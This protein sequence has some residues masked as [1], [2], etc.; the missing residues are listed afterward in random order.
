MAMFVVVWVIVSTAMGQIVYAEAEDGLYASN[1][2]PADG[3]E[4]VETDVLL[5]WWPGFG[6]TEHDVYLGTDFD[7]VNDIFSGPWDMDP[8]AEYLG[9]FTEPN[10]LVTGLS[11]NTMYYWR[12]DEV[13]GRLP[14]PLAGGVIYKGDVWSFNTGG[15]GLIAH[16]KL[17]EGSGAVAYDS[18]GI[19]DGTIYG[20]AWITGQLG[21]ALDFDGSNDYVSIPHDP[22]LNIT[23]DITIAAWVNFTRI[24]EYEGIVTKCVGVG[25]QNVPF[26]FRTRPHMSPL[27]F[28]RADAS[29]HER[30][31]SSYIAELGEWHHV[32]VRVE[33]KVPDFY[34]DG[35]ITGKG[36]DVV[37]TKTPTGNT[38]PV[39]IGRRD[40]GLYF[41]GSI[42]DVRIYDRALSALEIMELYVP[43][44]SGPIAH[45]KLD[46][47]TGSVA[48]DSAGTNDGTIYGADWTTG[49]LGG[50]LDFDGG[51]DCVDFGDIDE[52]EFGDRDFSISTWFYTKG[53]HDIGGDNSGVGMIISKFNW[54]S[55]GRQW[56]LSQDGSGSLLFYTNPTGTS[57]EWVISQNGGY[58]NRW[59]HI[60]GL[61]SGSS[62]DLY[63]DG[64]L[65][66]TGSTLGVVTGKPSNVYIGCRQDPTHRYA[67]FNGLIDDVRIYDRALSAGEVEQL[68]AYGGENLLVNGSFETMELISGGWPSTYGDWSGDHSYINAQYGNV[69]PFQGSRL[70]QFVGT[71]AFGCG[72]GAE[73]QVYQIVDVSAFADDI[74]A[75]KATTSASAY[76]NRVAGDAET[77]TEFAVDIRA[78]EGDPGSF[79]TLQDMGGMHLAE[80]S[81]SIITDGDPATWQQCL[82]QLV[83]P[84]NTD[85]VVVGIHAL[86]NV[87][88]DIEWPELDGHFADA[89]LLVMVIEPNVPDAVIYHVDGVNGSDL[90]TGLTKESA[91]ATIQRGINATEDGDTVL[92]WPGVYNETVTQGI[93]FMGKAITVKSA[94]DAAVLEVPGFTA[95]TFVRG[96]DTNSVL[97]NFVLRGSNTGILALFANPTINNVTVVDNDNGVIADNADPLI[98]NSI[99]YNNVNGDLFG[100]PEPITVKYSWLEAELD[101]PNMPSAGLISQWKFD[102]GAGPLAYDSAGTNHGAVA[103]A[104]WTT[105]LFGN[106]L[107]LDGTDDYVIVADNDSLTPSSGLTVSAWIFINAFSWSDR[108]AIVCKYDAGVGDRAY[109]LELGINNNPDKS[110]VCLNV[111]QV[112]GSPGYQTCGMTQLLERRWYHVI[113]TF[114]ANHQEIYVDGMEEN[115]DTNASI[116]DSIPNNYV[117]L[118][119][120]YSKDE[121]TFFNGTI[122]EVVIYDRALSAGEIEQVYDPMVNPLFVDAAG[123]DYHLL[124]ERGRYRATTDEWLLDDITSPC[125]DGGDPAVEPSN[126]R[127]PNGGKINMGAYGNSAY[128]SMSEWPV[129]GDINNDGRFNFMD[130]ALLLDGWLQELPWAQ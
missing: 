114:E 30:V 82:T 8:P 64:E 97:S 127:M 77:D 15:G 93:N 63:I 74:A 87:Y 118:Y 105:G 107:D 130:I 49:Q 51:G 46:E 10:I 65:N 80:A 81:V 72:G 110:T 36:A 57:S 103:G 17:D 6:V 69:W 86:E 60:V 34:V 100:S 28:L 71:N 23:G 19:N 90:N 25:G 124:S 122:D 2:N 20:A 92:V 70:M 55:D 33:N 84:P 95:V 42:D 50:A 79:P 5:S 59:V 109:S 21:G 112:P 44:E 54:S 41:D 11:D 16:W 68:Y 26:E 89:A 119:I 32:L 113:A 101:E 116:A 38:N 75:N 14:P 35:I 37:F 61:R 31:Y 9:T 98:T 85:Y 24:G 128:A 106:A 96:E 47:G 62:K 104:T 3:A 1:P 129:K 12:V 78:F 67:F 126:E 53:I 43:A 120:G 115:D 45:W 18:A 108:T 99:F 13:S 7:D 88:N 52:F 123:G 83:L 4:D 29:G 73:S 56:Y 22:A 66:N 39:L 58:Q 117:S 102:E 94:A 76:F 125:I 27:T 48:Y 40:D 111:A 91:F 121:N